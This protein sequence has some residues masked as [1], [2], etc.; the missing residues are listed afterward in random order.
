MSASV[1]V[2][3]TRGAHICLN[4]TT[5]MFKYLVGNQDKGYML[6]EKDW[7]VLES[8]SPYEKSKLLAEQSAWEFVKKMP[9]KTKTKLLYLMAII[10]LLV[11]HEIYFCAILLQYICVS[12]RKKLIINYDIQ[13]K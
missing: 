8:G 1:L 4:T 6:T 7:A 9:G 3:I 12:T 13:V 2:H 5:C 10:P 11:F